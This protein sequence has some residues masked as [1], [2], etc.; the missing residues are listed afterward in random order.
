M[1][2]LSF[3]PLDHEPTLRALT[4]SDDWLM[5]HDDINSTMTHVFVM[6]AREGWEVS[7]YF[8]PPLREADMVG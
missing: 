6:W 2:H 3:L 5:Q 4:L 1:L 7:A 8:R